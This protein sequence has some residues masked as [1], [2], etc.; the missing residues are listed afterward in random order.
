MG[1]LMRPVGTAIERGLV[2]L[3]RALGALGGRTIRW[4]ERTDWA[5]PG[6][7]GFRPDVPA[8]GIIIGWVVATPDDIPD[9]G[10]KPEACGGLTGG[11]VP[12]AGGV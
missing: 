4:V 7:A 12:E 11:M 9:A 10:T 6:R 8:R 5:T 1:R 3:G 2:A